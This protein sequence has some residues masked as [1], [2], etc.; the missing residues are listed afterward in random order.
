MPGVLGDLPDALCPV[1]SAA[2]E[3]RDGFVGEMDLDAVTVELDLVGS[4]TFSIEDASA[5][6]TK[7]G[8][9]ALTVIASVFLRR[10]VAAIVTQHA[11]TN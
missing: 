8:R 11:T 2:R 7:P 10:N 6:L 1:M 9:D 3:D 4:S 5:G